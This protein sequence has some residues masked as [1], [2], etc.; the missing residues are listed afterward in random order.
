MAKL[1]TRLSEMPPV[2]LAYL[3]SQLRA[4]KEILAAEPIAVIG[5][6]CRFPGGGE[7]PETFWEF[8][9]GAGDAT[10]EVPRER[11]DIDEIYDPT[12]GV[13][14]KVYTRRGAFIED[15][16]LFDPGFFGIPPRDAKDM[17]PQQR[18]LHEECWRAL[19]RAGIPPAGLVGSRTGVFVGLM[20]NDYNVLGITSG[21]E[22]FAASLNYPSMAAGRIAHT[23]GFQG[24]AL[25]V[26]TACSSSAV[27]IHLACQSLRNDES[28]L[29]LAGGVSLS[30]SPITMM[31]GCENRMLSVDGRCKTFDASADGFARG[32]G[33]GVVVLKRLSDAL[34]KGDPILGIIRGSA[35]NHDG[36]S[37]G[38]MVPNGR[39]QERVIRMAL[40]G[41][42]VEPHQISY[43]EAH[44]T[45]T[46]LGDPIEMEAIR[47]V[48]GRKTTRSE[49]LLVGSVKTNIGHLEAAAG[50]SGLIKV[51]L[52]LQN[53]IIPAHLNFERPNPNIR[54]DD[55]PVIIPTS[56]RPWPRGE[57]RR[58]AGVSSFGFSG[59][60]AHLI[61]EEA[62]LTARPPLEKERPIH[63]L[64]MSAKT[65]ASLD[66]LVE[67]HERALP[68]DDA[69]LGDW[70]YTAN[71]GRSHFEH[72]LAVSGATSASLR[73][74]LARLRA[75][76]LRP[77][78]EPRQGTE[79]PKPVFLFTGQ[80]ALQPGVGRELYE[81]QPA[82]RAALQRCSSVL[83]S[84]LGLRLEN[85]LFGEEAPALLEDTR[86]AQP[87]LVA[88]EYALSELWAS[89]GVIPGALVGH[90]LGE[91]AAA[92]V[93]GVMSIEDALGLSVERARLMS[94]A[95]GE[96]AMLAI[97]ASQEVTAQAI[98]PYPGV[99]SFAAINGPEDMVVSGGKSALEALKGDLERRGIHCKFLRVPHAFHSPLMD[100]VLG[101]FAEVLKGV[102]LS[103]P[104]IPFVST[105]EGRPV[106]DPLTQPEYW[107]RHLREPVHFAKGL[108][109]LREQGHRTY[110][111]LGPAPILAGIGR[112]LFPE[113]EELCWLPSLRP[114]EG[115]TAQM[116]SSLSALY[117]RGFEVDWAAFDAPFE[118][119]T[120]DL[121]TY[122]FQRDRYWIE[123][124]NTGSLQ[125]MTDRGTSKDAA[126]PL[127]GVA[128]SLAGSKET[129]FAARLSIREPAFIAEHRILGMTVLPAACYVE[130]ALGAVYHAD[131][132]E[133]PI[134]LKAIELE[135]PLVFTEAEGC[136]VQTVLTPEEA[137]SRFEIYA[138]GAGSERRWARLA[139]GRVE[140]G[141]GWAG[142]IDLKAEL[143]ERFPQQGS[144]VA[145]YELMDRSGLEYGPSFR[146]IHEL[147]FGENGCLA[148]V[149]LPDSLIV[150]LDSYRLH[151][152][153]LDACF[154]AVAAVFMEDDAQFK[155]ERRQRM[156]VAIERLR[157]FKK[158]GS[159]VWVHVQRNSRS[160]T[161]AE[162]LSASLRIL[163]ED[164]EVIA[165]VDG[166]LLK[167]VDRNAFKASFA[168][169]TRELLFELAWREQRAS[170]ER[171]RVVSPPGHWLL[172]ADSGSVAERL[173]E[174]VLQHSRTCVTV[175]P[176]AGYE[177]L[178]RDHYRLDPADPAGFDRLFQDLSAGGVAPA[179]VAY[180]WGLDERGAAELSAEELAGVTA[181]SSAGAL[182]LVQAMARVAWAQRPALWMVTRG[183]VAAVP[184]DGVGGLSQ[185]PIWGLG[186]AAAIEH[187]EL[188]CRLADLDGDE[189]APAR[190]FQLMAEPPEENM[191]ALRGSQ[192]LGARL[193]RPDKA[194]SR[195]SPVR[196]RSDGTYL[197]TGGMGALGLAT[198]EWLVE[199]GARQLVLVGR[200]EPGE[201]VKARINALTARGC[202][203]T[204][205][206]ADVSRREEVQR[207]V[208]GISARESQ[209]LGI[210]HIA[211]VLDDGVFMLQSR[212][213]IAQ[214][215]VPKV[216]GAWNLHLA[217]AQ[218]PLDL[219]VM[220]SSA[221]SL[222]GVAGQA[223]Y[224]AANSFLDAL[225]Y[226][227]SRQGLPALSVNWGRWSGEGMAAKTSAKGSTQG[228]DAGNL[229]PRRALQ[230][231]GDLLM[232]DVVQMGVV[233]FAVAAV[234]SA[235]SPGHGPLFSEL[236]M[237]EQARSSSVARMHELLGELKSADSV[238][239]RGLLTHYVQGRMAPLLGFAPD[240]EVFQKKVSL[241]EMGLDSL[242]AVELKNRIG[243]ELGVDLPMARFIDGTNL[244]GIVEALH[245]QLELNELLA[246][247][248]SAAVEIEELTL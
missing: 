229:S 228:V 86:N 150:G 20:H 147:R 139:Q 30:L 183:A 191:M 24:P 74:G 112:R 198:A 137:N 222:V 187:P 69:S 113:A 104:H 181:R 148:H 88:L 133:R 33:C 167:Q 189:G 81:T 149:R 213:R 9:K 42:G 97:S 46:A 71:V 136:D 55:L 235:L 61:V 168:D 70:C 246:R 36:R 105:L 115:E 173:K 56:M 188:G 7:R 199:E 47:S 35:V 80:G 165:E 72:R 54:W 123:A 58:I 211:G 119:R 128:L 129:R 90:S 178:G 134:E 174:L 114:S 85:L 117:V 223:N 31:F 94:A 244:E 95:P 96:G 157:W 231:L 37:S 120:R 192:L 77:D 8:L 208:E 25:T 238:R 16:D 239:R 89:W 180:L 142:R 62:P 59:T 159:S 176:G 170:Q 39:A 221:A 84:K 190:L 245:S 175:S 130:M 162:V 45:G 2:K 206:R 242:R 135:R 154:Q 100:P 19:E 121:P 207:L 108:G 143:F 48:F 38:L 92:A 220:Y 230:I 98:E 184:S 21:V 28:D 155:G 91:Y 138:Q 132:R 126:H 151:P 217:T 34:A 248:P 76:K 164:G 209:L 107:C 11:W 18:L 224:V 212:E 214:V 22:M 201:A 182:H 101:P 204:V 27:C 50:V 53:E 227:R 75:E 93:A 5:M 146:A 240:H 49:P 52:S 17:D 200:G 40:D 163:G 144:V 29:A 234:D 243:R 177:K 197:L 44:G 13:R 26:D 106:T 57:K 116:L 194:V 233:S 219:F 160:S 82:F 23:L 145:L 79:S 15:V 179:T 60:N 6:S 131:S 1:S 4:K 166:L 125:Y 32:E 205:T 153:I 195:S 124:Q 64:T 122:P 51:I 185:T 247:P 196:I 210:F 226:H 140:E 216:L 41:C 14:G 158:A 241:N 3:A 152:L 203:V 109:F 83:E 78:R 43:V 68:N 172:F 169:S 171:D 10:R 103:V 186:R 12:P 66:A 237:R 202:H 232:L 236:M 156:P 111:E 65:D 127:A 102:K 225:A 118:R 215:F 99:V 141:S 63:V 67:A 73:A 218:L 161:S 193:V 87:V 110:L